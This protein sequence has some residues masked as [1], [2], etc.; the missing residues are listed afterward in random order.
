[1]TVWTEGEIDAGG[2]RIHFHRT[3]NGD[4]PAV[5][6]IH[7][8]SD[9]G[10]CWSRI[11]RVLETDYDVV[12]IDARNHGESATAAGDLSD[13]AADAAAV[14]TGL[15][16]DRPAVV[17]H[18]IGAA[19]AAE[20][21]ASRPDLVSRMVLEDPPWSDAQNDAGESAR[22]SRDDVRA[23]LKSLAA[24]TDAELLELGRTQHPE[25]HEIEYPAW[26]ASKRQV[27]EQAADSL[28]SAG[29]S[30]V[31]DRIECPT[32][33]IHGDPER[34]GIVTPELAQKLAD[35]NHHVSAGAI[36]NSGHNVRRENFDRFI[37]LVGQF[38]HDA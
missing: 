28:G 37:E 20:L 13:L 23:Y 38:L 14:I 11:A 35:S 34:G 30:D 9:N 16:L 7:G 24:M 5:V 32:L 29:W 10:L 26:V 1:M 36:K 12:M 8:F 17:G 22:S 2:V 33:L 18:S 21:A 4:Q 3:G 25:W 31:I 19:T 6:L 27:R 15:G